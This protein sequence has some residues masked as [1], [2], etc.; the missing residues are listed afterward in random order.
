MVFFVSFLIH[1]IIFA[2][3]FV[4]LITGTFCYISDISSPE[5][6]SWRMGVAEAALMIGLPSGMAASSIILKW[7]GYA[8]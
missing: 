5:E 3:G 4:T 1:K 8:V 7:G 6:R 2:G